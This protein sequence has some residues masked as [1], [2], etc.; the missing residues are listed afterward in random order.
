MAIEPTSFRLPFQLG[1]DVHPQVASALRYAFTGLKDLNDAIK[2]LKDQQTPTP[3]P[4]TVTNGIL[5]A[6]SGG[7]P[8]IIPVP[9]A[10]NIG[11]VNDQTG[12]VSYA[13]QTGDFGTL[14][15]TEPIVPFALTLNNAVNSP[16][17]C[18]VENLGTARLTATPTSGLVNN[19]A[20]WSLIGGQ[21]ALIFYSG[22][23]W[24][25]TTLPAYLLGG[26]TGGGAVVL[27]SGA[28][29]TSFH[30]KGLVH[31]DSGCSVIFDS[32][33][34]AV[35]F[36]GTGVTSLPDLQSFANNAAAISGGLIVGNLYKTGGDPDLVAVVH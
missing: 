10:G 13:L 19:L 5:I 35:N 25:I 22:T 18:V 17:F 7:V 4:A 36:K 29:L 24:W 33:S 20:S 31:V 21:S 30:M 32:G 9:P 12:S 1:E 14:I 26:S 8:P 16:F 23:E 3:A 15:V 34:Q 2:S 27:D 28:I 6:G 11:N